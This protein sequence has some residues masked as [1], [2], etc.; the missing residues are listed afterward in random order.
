M[1]LTLIDEC[2]KPWEEYLKHPV[3]GMGPGRV[4]NRFRF[5]RERLERN[6]QSM[7]IDRSFQESN[8][9][10]GKRRSQKPMIHYDKLVRDGIPSI[11]EKAGKVPVTDTISPAEMRA[12]LDRKLHEEVQEYLESHSVEEMADV[13]EVLHGIAF[14]RGIK[15]EQVESERIRK[16]EERGGFE[17]GIRLI[18]VKEG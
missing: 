6:S 15:W 12:A 14:H 11:I 3:Y 18:E 7:G 2:E 10:G 9:K 17:K 16:K 1:I 4:M 8:P 13:L 5:F